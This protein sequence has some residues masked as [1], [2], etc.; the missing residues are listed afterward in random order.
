MFVKS[1][2]GS[3]LVFWVGCEPCSWLECHSVSGNPD[4][5]RRKAKGK[6]AQL[7]KLHSGC[8]AH[9][10]QAGQPGSHTGSSATLKWTCAVPYLL[11][12]TSSSRG[13]C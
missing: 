1:A 8:V 6:T 3:G 13:G 5:R 4:R 7:E 10:A 9:R 2:S 11:S 12:P